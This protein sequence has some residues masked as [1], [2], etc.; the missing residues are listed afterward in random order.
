MKEV[1]IKSNQ[2][3]KE[4]PQCCP[5][6]PTHIRNAVYSHYGYNYTGGRNK[7]P[8]PFWL[9]V[10]KMLSELEEKKTK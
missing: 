10:Q 6:I 7:Q 5:T 9:L 2:F 4:Q 1:K 3:G 8:V